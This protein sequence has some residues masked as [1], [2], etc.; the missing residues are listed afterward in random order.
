MKRINIS[1]FL[2][3]GLILQFDTIVEKTVNTEGEPEFV[4]GTITPSLLNMDEL[5]AYLDEQHDNVNDS[6]EEINSFKNEIKNEAEVF[7][8]WES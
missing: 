4:E 1:K 6:N 2:A 5:K 8:F 7:V 3:D